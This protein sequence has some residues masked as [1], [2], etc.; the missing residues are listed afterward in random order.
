M[1]HLLQQAL[2][3]MQPIYQTADETRENMIANPLF[4][5]TI[6]RR[7]ETLVYNFGIVITIEYI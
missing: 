1:P 6:H 3:T 4:R 7:L 2:P 5:I